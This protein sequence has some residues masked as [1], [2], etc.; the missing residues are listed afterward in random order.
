MRV[1]GLLGKPTLL[2]AVKEPHIP[3]KDIKRRTEEQNKLDSEAF[4][5]VRG[6]STL[7]VPLMCS[8]WLTVCATKM[9]SDFGCLE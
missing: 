1:A 5:S 6:K 4:L 7:H 3:K 2:P 8:C 9:G